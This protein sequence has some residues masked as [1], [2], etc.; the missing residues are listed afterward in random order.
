MDSARAVDLRAYVKPVDWWCP[1]CDVIAHTCRP[2]PHTQFHRC[3]GLAGLD[4]PMVPAGVKAMTIAIERDDYVGKEIVTLDGNGRP[5]MAVEIV[6]DDG[7]DR[8]VYAPCATAEIHL[9]L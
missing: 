6:R 7:T 3:P 2:E 4:A 8:A 1:R 5:I 9:E